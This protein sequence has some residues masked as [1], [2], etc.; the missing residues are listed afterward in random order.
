MCSVIE[1]DPIKCA[2]AHCDQDLKATAIRTAL[3][4]SAILDYGYN[5]AL[6]HAP[7]AWVL[8]ASKTRGNYLWLCALLVGLIHQHDLR[9]GVRGMV[10]ARD[11]L[12][13]ATNMASIVPAG[14]L[15]FWPS[16]GG[17]FS[18]FVSGYRAKYREKDKYATWKDPGQRP[19]WMG[20]AT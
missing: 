8:W 13:H 20:G 11:V 16:V 10:K 9:F 17:E 12:D 18:G 6:C 15:T 7:S 2:A 4:L 19:D 1:P 14:R 5:N 3:V